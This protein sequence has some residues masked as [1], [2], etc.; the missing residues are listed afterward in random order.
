MIAQHLGSLTLVLAL[1]TGVA[2]PAPAAD[3]APADCRIE[4]AWDG[5]MT[6][7]FSA[8]RP[9]GALQLMERRVARGAAGPVLRLVPLC[10]AAR[11]VAAGANAPSRFGPIVAVRRPRRVEFFRRWQYIF[12]VIWEPNSNEKV[13][14]WYYCWYHLE[15]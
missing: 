7:A 1:A 15:N 6:D 5:A 14:C 4:A 13:S 11:L 12:R 9:S 8:P 10:A 2:S 3:P